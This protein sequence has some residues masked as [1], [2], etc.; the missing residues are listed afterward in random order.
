VRPWAR[1][2][3]AMRGCRVHGR[4]LTTMSADRDVPVQH[5]FVLYIQA[6]GPAIGVPV[7]DGFGLFHRLVGQDHLHPLFQAGNGPRAV[8]PGRHPISVS[9]SWVLTLGLC[10]SRCDMQGDKGVA[11]NRTT[12]INPVSW[13][14]GNSRRSPRR[15]APRRCAW[16]RRK[17]KGS[18]GCR[19]Q[20]HLSGAGPLTRDLETTRVLLIAIPKISWFAEK[21]RMGPLQLCLQWFIQ[22]S[23]VQGFDGGKQVS[24]RR[25]ILASHPRIPRRSAPLRSAFLRFV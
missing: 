20:G 23:L 18:A 4:R 6:D 11:T 5:G 2:R 8:P 19:Q 9:A 12:P 24:L 7:D 25:L 13:C 16:E 14:Q 22:A 1:Q 15:C 10:M 17:F 21:M 3:R